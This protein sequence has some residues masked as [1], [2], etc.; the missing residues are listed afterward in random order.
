MSPHSRVVSE[1]RCPSSLV[2]ALAGLS[3]PEPLGQAP[4][5]LARIE[6]MNALGLQITP[7]HLCRYDA[8]L[9]T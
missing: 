2:D 3:D 1:Q 4:H 5:P 8:T 9:S 7:E 6:F